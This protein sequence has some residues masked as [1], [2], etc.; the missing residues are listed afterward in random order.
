MT[1]FCIQFPEVEVMAI[2]DAETAEDAVRAA[3]D[4]VIETAKRIGIPPERILKHYSDAVVR[5]ATEEEI[6]RR[7]RRR[8][9]L[10]RG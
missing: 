2:K 6:Q 3:L 7:T 5:P 4:D 10:G 1:T 8:F 9:G